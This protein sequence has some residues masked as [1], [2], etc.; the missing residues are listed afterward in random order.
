MITKLKDD[1]F[2]PFTIE[3]TFQTQEDVNKYLVEI[4]NC[5]GITSDLYEILDRNVE[6]TI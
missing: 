6:E 3:L 4:A 2:Q 5:G 1:G